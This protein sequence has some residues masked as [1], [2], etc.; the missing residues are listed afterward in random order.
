MVASGTAT[1]ETGLMAVPMVIAYRISALNYF[2]L[3]K[4]VRGVKDVGLVNIVA[5]RRIVPELVQTDST[6]GNM[7]DEV[8]AF[9]NDADYHARTRSDLIAMRSRLGDAG[10]SKRAAAVVREFL[11]NPGAGLAD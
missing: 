11:G 8:A 3:T 4:V 1:L 2:L 6:A 5:G 7:A 10:A 9:L